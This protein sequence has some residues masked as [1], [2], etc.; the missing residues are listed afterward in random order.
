VILFLLFTYVNYVHENWSW[1]AYR[2]A[3]GFLWKNRCDSLLGRDRSRSLGTE[4]MEALPRWDSLTS[5]PRWLLNTTCGRPRAGELEDR[6][7]C[8]R[9]RRPWL[10]W[11]GAPVRTLR[12]SGFE[13]LMSRAVA[14][15]QLG[16]PVSFASAGLL[17]SRLG[18]PLSC[19]SVVLWNQG[20]LWR[21]LSPS[22]S[23][24]HWSVIAPF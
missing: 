15:W 4:G 1:H 18:R 13:P 7:E 8:V 17:G 21:P 14:G 2:F 24:V 20:H 22:R 9:P 11:S 3:L 19:W 10:C 12:G 5:C 6:P 23:R 16:A